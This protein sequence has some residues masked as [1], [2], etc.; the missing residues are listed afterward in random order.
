MMGW[1]EKH[2][3][4]CAACDV[5]ALFNPVLLKVQNIFDGSSSRWGQWTSV[6]PLP[7]NHFEA[8]QQRFFMGD[9]DVLMNREGVTGAERKLFEVWNVADAATAIA[10]L[11]DLAAN[12][13]PTPGATTVINVTSLMADMASR[14]VAGLEDVHGPLEQLNLSLVSDLS[15]Q[16]MKLMGLGRPH[17]LRVLAPLFVRTCNE[18]DVERLARGVTLQVSALRM[19]NADDALEGTLMLALADDDTDQ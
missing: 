13:S 1:L 18:V 4:L 17:A 10:Q 16:V 9:V 8:V 14:I 5:A 2:A 12:P 3:K 7:Q 19:L 11:R 15:K 6:W